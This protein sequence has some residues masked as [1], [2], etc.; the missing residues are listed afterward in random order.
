MK[1]LIIE[2]EAAASKRLVN[3]LKEMDTSFVILGVL[4][5]V[6][7][8]VEWFENNEEP[9]LILSDV[10]LSDGLS[11]EIF[12]SVAID[13]PVIFITGYDQYTIQAFKVN[14]I[15]YLL[16]PVSVEELKKSLDKY[17]RTK[18]KFDDLAK[19][20][21]E[22]LLRSLN[23]NVKK[24]KSRILVRQRES[25]IAVNTEN[26]AYVL[27]ENQI[28]YIYTKD[29][30]SFIIDHTLEQL[31]AMLNPEHFFR[32]NRQ[33]IVNIDSI[34]SI[35]IYF[36]N[37]LKLELIPKTAIDVIVARDRVAEFKKWISK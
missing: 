8:S 13:T 25:F 24:Y 14:S 10:E 4:E 20:N 21:F 27:L 6:K 17:Q 9:D 2:D 15:D 37:R 28:V 33:F 32:I 31:E 11:F 12:E 30:K 34:K 22:E 36:N 18:N 7:E 16:K 26:I 29:S 19:S 23:I 1:I 5:S 3:I 35:D